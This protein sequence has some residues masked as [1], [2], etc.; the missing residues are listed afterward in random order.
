[1][2]IDNRIIYRIVNSSFKLP[3]WNNWEPLSQDEDWEIF[4]HHDRFNK[5]IFCSDKTKFW[6][7]KGILD[8]HIVEIDEAEALAILKQDAENDCD[9]AYL[10]LIDPPTIPCPHCGKPVEYPSGPYA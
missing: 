7:K 3:R 5:A 6:I 1:M 9:N 10:Y 4:S 8:G 2:D